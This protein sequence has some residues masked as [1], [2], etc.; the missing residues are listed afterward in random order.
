MKTLDPWKILVG[1]AGVLALG[2]GG[3]WL[4]QGL[5]LVH[6]RPILCFADCAELQEP[7]TT[8]TIIGLVTAAAGAWGLVHSFRSLRAARTR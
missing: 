1:L 7:S 8:W 2:L 3:L 5:G 4:L 6:V